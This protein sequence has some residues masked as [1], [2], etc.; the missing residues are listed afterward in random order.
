[1][2]KIKKMPQNRPNGHK[3]NRHLQLKP[4]KI[5][6]N[7]DF[8]FENMPSGNPGLMSSFRALK[9]WKINEVCS[10]KRQR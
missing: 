10:L 3:I 4:S 6:P 9:D 2:Y 8:G 5:Y 1:M 7:W